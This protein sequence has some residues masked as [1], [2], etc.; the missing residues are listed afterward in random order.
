MKKVHKLL[1]LS[2]VVALSLN[3]CSKD[4][5]TELAA[6]DSQ[7]VL[8]ETTIDAAFE[9]VDNIGY[10][11]L[12]GT[13]SFN[14]RLATASNALA[15][16]AT[17]NADQ[18]TRTIVIDFGSEGCADALGRVRMGKITL[19]YTESSWTMTFDGF[20]IDDKTI[21]GERTISIVNRSGNSFTMHILLKNGKISWADG[22]FISREIDR[23]KTWRF[24][25]GEWE[26]TGSANGTNRNGQSYSSTITSPL[27]YQRSC[28]EKGV[29]IPVK[30][31]L[32]I[33][34]SNPA[35]D[36]I[37]VDFG[38]GSCDKLIKVTVGD[39]TKEIEVGTRAGA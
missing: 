12:V 23:T 13:G 7:A 38:D 22:T 32:F 19:T 11:A 37:T 20:K 26:I 2:L 14:G 8:A 39:F 10:S 4:D 35:K 25:E 5:E 31:V 24:A 3:A 33:E 30:G 15:S 28:L 16:C 6:E 21:E 1:F 27:L 17:V 9:E 29:H 18:E 34:R 36:S